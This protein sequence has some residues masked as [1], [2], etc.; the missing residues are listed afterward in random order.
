M[1]NKIKL[2]Y[3]NLKL[4]YQS[5]Y[6]VRRAQKERAIFYV[7]HF[8]PYEVKVV[9]GNTY[10][11]MRRVGKKKGLKISKYVHLVANPFA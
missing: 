5:K 8:P 2:W 3:V 11:S 10:A 6:A 7:L 1:K 4:Q 9:D